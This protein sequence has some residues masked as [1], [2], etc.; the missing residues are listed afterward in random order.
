MA[1]CRRL[2]L[3]VVLSMVLVVA[4]GM[5]ADDAK[6][7]AA[8]ETDKQVDPAKPK[9]LS[10]AVLNG[11]AFL[12]RQQQ[13][14]GGWSEGIEQEH[15][16]RRF[17]STSTV[18]HTSLACLALLRLGYSPQKGTHAKNLEQG[19]QFVCT[20]VEKADKDGLF[21]S[22]L[23][24]NA[25]DPNKMDNGF[26]GMA[27]MNGIY[28]HFKLGR[29]IDTF[30]ALN[31]LV[32]ARGHMAD[33]KGNE[34]IAAAL[35]K[36]LGKVQARQQ[37]DGTWLTEGLAPELTH[38]LAVRGLQRA[39]QVGVDVDETMVD[40]AIKASRKPRLQMDLGGQIEM[41]ETALKKAKQAKNPNNAVI[42]NLEKT[43]EKTREFKK[44]AENP[45]VGQFGMNL[46]GDA[47]AL[48]I[49]LDALGTAQQKRERAQAALA[50]AVGDAQRDQAKA[51]LE[52]C[53]KAEKEL[54]D[55]ISDALRKIDIKT[56]YQQVGF[57][58]GEEYLSFMLVNELLLSRGGKDAVYWQKTLATS[59]ERQQNRDGSWL[60][61]HCL[62]GKNLC[63]AAVLMALS[64]DRSPVVLDIRRRET[65]APASMLE[66]VPPTGSNK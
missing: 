42:A 5:G 40:K 23:Q 3:V 31:L 43:L 7:P 35:S 37:A 36:V 54:R 26:A 2:G 1:A 10:Q 65:E 57:S 4:S 63:T 13:R 45:D 28:I 64:A 8:K 11:V 19:I 18:A 48:G 52:K 50:G 41:L 33:D 51:E 22:A 46:Y 29:H 62:T 32:E 47:G 66:V 58:G 61:K 15:F 34:R 55:R 39:R 44:Q 9:A 21:V 53:T 12:V 24:Q 16:N 27:D 17:V 14:D 60:G 56:H 6:K 25:K 30:L 20:Q 49:L 59:M 38:A